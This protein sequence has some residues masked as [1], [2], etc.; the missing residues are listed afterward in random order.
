MFAAMI[1]PV[2]AGLGGGA[3][4]VGPPTP[5]PEFPPPVPAQA[6]ALAAADSQLLDPLVRLT[7][8][9]VW[10]RTG[11]PSDAKAVSLVTNTWSRSALTRRP[12]PSGGKK[13][14]I[15][16]RL[17][18]R[19]YAANE[20]DLRDVVKVYE[21]FRFDPTFSRIITPDLLKFF[22]VDPSSLPKTT[23]VVKRKRSVEK[24]W[25]GG[26]DKK[27]V[28]YPKGYKYTDEE[29]YE[30]PEEV[31]FVASSD[32]V[33]R[34]PDPTADPATL[35]ILRGT[36]QSEAVLTSHD[37][38]I[39]RA[40]S[41][42]KD[43]GAYATVY[44]GLYYDLSGIKTVEQ[45]GLKKGTDEDLL[46]QTLGLGKIEQGFTAAQLFEELRSDQRVAMFR[47][48]VTGKWRRGDIFPTPNNRRGQ[49]IVA[50]TH[51][52][53]DGSVDLTQNPILNLVEV[54]DNAREV[55]F[56][57][58]NGTQGAA[59]FNDKGKLQNEV[60]PD[61]A[62]DRTVPSPHT[63]RLQCIVSCWRCHWGNGSDGW[64]PM[65]NDV[66]KLFGDKLD[67]FG[68]AVVRDQGDAVARIAGLYTGSPKKMLQR[69]RDDLAEVVLECT[70]PWPDS[71]DQTDACKR[72]ADRVALIYQEYWYDVVDVRKALRYLGVD[73]P[74]DPK[75][76]SRAWAEL[77]PPLKNARVG[78]VV[79][80]DPRVDAFKV[81]LT[82]N[83]ADWDLIRSFVAERAAKRAAELGAKK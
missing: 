69:A 7:V 56:S 78:G 71:P 51:D 14:G 4:P 57:R 43:K 67:A 75:V 17:D 29:E 35:T 53:N 38:Y 48:G 1:L 31:P 21:E 58:P 11:D 81:G 72:S 49:G 26:K 9:Y 37:Y 16:L 28:E 50:V 27:G 60:P 46:F 52:P 68:D 3:E 82:I 15:L 62:T 77:L 18:L 65:E 24:V 59:L 47:S 20:T 42:I 41:T 64:Q 5:R 63:G 54:K 10:I 6:V 55:L 32:S 74:G 61:V 39:Y 83:R 22:E 76:A 36:H 19:H 66:K 40:T 12:V 8:R 33:A 2:L 70:G 13:D 73:A 25:P 80:E 30:E 44:G 45:A 23:R 79:L 34:F